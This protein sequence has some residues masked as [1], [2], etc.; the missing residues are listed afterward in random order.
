MA[1]DQVSSR[2]VSTSKQMYAETLSAVNTLTTLPLVLNLFLWSP[3]S[4]T[5][6]K[7]CLLPVICQLVH[8]LISSSLHAPCCR[9]NKLMNKMPAPYTANSAPIE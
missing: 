3:S 1:A 2:S 7:N 4:P 9:L 5:S 6:E 8:L